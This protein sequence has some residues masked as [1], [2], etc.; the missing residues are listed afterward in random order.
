MKFSRR[1]LSSQILLLV[2]AGW[3]SGLACIHHVWL[4]PSIKS[5]LEKQENSAAVRWIEQSLNGLA[6]E[7]RNI[8]G[9]CE[10]FAKS[11]EAGQRLQAA[12]RHRAPST[13]PDGPLHA[14]SYSVA[15]CS[16]DRRVLSLAG[17]LEQDGPPNHSTT[18]PM[19]TDLSGSAVFPAGWAGS[20]FTGLVSLGGRSCLFARRPIGPPDQPSGYAVVVRAIDPPML[21]DLSA[22]T[23]VNVMVISSRS[24]T[25]HSNDIASWSTGNGSLSAE[26]MLKDSLGRS[27]GRLQVTGSV[28][29]FNA[30]AERMRSAYL[31][32][33][34]WLIGSAL[35]MF[36]VVY[37]LFIRPLS[38]LVR[39]LGDMELTQKRRKLSAGLFA[40]T[41]IL[42][43][44]FSDVMDRI[45]QLS[46]TDALTGLKN[47]RH[48][49]LLLSHEFNM[50][51]RHN[52]PL[53]VLMIDVDHF[54]MVN[55]RHGHLVGD[56]VLQMVARTIQDACRKSDVAGRYGGEEF[57]LILPRTSTDQ[58]LVLG[59]RIR[60]EVL[61]RSIMHAEE[62][63]KVTISVG[64]A[65]MPQM[66]CQRPED[67]IDHADRALYAAKHAGRNRTICASQLDEK[68]QLRPTAA[69]DATARPAVA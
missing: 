36:A 64:V 28:I 46:E 45:V 29:D 43:R 15:L 31:V 13:L 37:A 44:K 16:R 3:V 56:E 39:R 52:A 11:A 4:V 27:I 18:W 54:K 66:P 5:Q 60:S 48:Y 62:L 53:A 6:R 61:H 49:Q 22:Q 63:V 38:I 35:F 30:S 9:L 21:A 24:Q 12:G 68:N 51:R 7:R 67:L 47:R 58:A 33:L 42:A 19:G 17:W 57:S 41:G 8:D 55:D 59:E 1:W 65:S 20:S 10:S 34:L 14:K 40:E 2:I 25:A 69:P 50:S 23:G 32:Q 26:V